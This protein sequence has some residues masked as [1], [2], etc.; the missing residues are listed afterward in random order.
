MEEERTKYD[1]Q[2]D[3]IYKPTVYTPQ[4]TGANFTCA[5]WCKSQGLGP[6]PNGTWLGTS[7]DCMWNCGNSTIDS[8]NNELV[9]TNPNIAYY[10]A[11]FAKEAS[12]Y[13]KC[14]S[15]IAAQDENSYI[16]LNPTNIK[17]PISTNGYVT[18]NGVWTD[19]GE[20][21]SA[22][23]AKVCCCDGVRYTGNE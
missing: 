19:F 12:P 11:P 13:Y 2:M 16:G 10:T 23:L 1:K 14:S 9:P 17:Y 21:C 7:P 6:P 4:G 15:C 20:K 3:Q 22:S 8:S 18:L 5:G